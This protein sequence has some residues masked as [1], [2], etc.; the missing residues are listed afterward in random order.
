MIILSEVTQICLIKLCHALSHM[1]MPALIIDISVFNW[2]TLEI[3]EPVPGH[4][5][6]AVSREGRA[7]RMKVVERRERE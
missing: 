1:W 3:R 2:S 4:G 5:E 6:E 7:D